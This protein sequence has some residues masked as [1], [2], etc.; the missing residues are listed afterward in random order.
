MYNTLFYLL[1]TLGFMSESFINKTYDY[2]PPSVYLKFYDNHTFRLQYTPQDKP[3]RVLQGKWKELT[4]R[5]IALYQSVSSGVKLVSSNP[6]FKL[7]KVVTFNQD[8]SEFV[9]QNSRFALHKT[10]Q[11]IASKGKYAFTMQG[12]TQQNKVKRW[13]IRFG[14]KKQFELTALGEKEIV[15]I[16]GKWAKIDTQKVA[17]F[18]LENKINKPLAL[19]SVIEFNPQFTR[20]SMDN[21]T[22]V[23]SQSVKD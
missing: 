3:T 23:H 19:P 14:Q 13:Q 7:P 11:T 10:P 16:Q 21:Y 9:Y 4:S 17:L 20:F 18:G 1:A 2:V 8:F 5:E 15:K 6:T 12:Y 22:F